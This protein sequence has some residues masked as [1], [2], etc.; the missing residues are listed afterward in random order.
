MEGIVFSYYL[1]HLTWKWHFRPMFL[2]FVPDKKSVAKACCW[3]RERGHTSPCG[4]GRNVGFCPPAV[5]L[6]P[7]VTT[8]II[9]HQFP[10]HA[11]DAPLCKCK[12]MTR[13]YWNQTPLDTD[14]H[15]HT[16][17]SHIGIYK[18]QTLPHSGPTHKIVATRA[19]AP[20]LSPA[21]FSPKSRYPSAIQLNIQWCLLCTAQCLCL[22]LSPLQPQLA[23]SY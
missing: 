2:T 12:L 22:C 6:Q 10:L 19:H 16:N 20:V 11:D 7:A 4:S 1:I 23:L 13:G 14:P 8:W 3:S 21:K 9:E 18:I 17:D 5:S 15:T